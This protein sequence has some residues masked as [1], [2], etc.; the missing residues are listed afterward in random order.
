MKTARAP[1]RTREAVEPDGGA[2][3]SGRFL[4]RLDPGL[5]AALREAARAEGVSLNEYCVRRLAAPAGATALAGVEEVV[6][7]AASLLGADLV[8]VVAFGSWAR[9]EA[10]SGSD[11]DLVIVVEDG[12]V[13]ERALYRRWESEP[14]SVADRSVDVHFAHLPDPERA[15]P[16][17][18]GEIAID[19]IVVFERELRLSRRLAE[20]RRSIAAGRLVQRF[21]HGQPYWVDLRESGEPTEVEH[22]KTEIEQAATE[23]TEQMEQTEHA[24]AD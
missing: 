2:P 8:A 19:G 20:L 18:W 15:S 10:R 24:E 9:G 14:I 4:L 11:L 23:Q 17:L 21:S 7:R 16:G 1:S 12:V 6:R 13:L 3:A 22:A 5:H